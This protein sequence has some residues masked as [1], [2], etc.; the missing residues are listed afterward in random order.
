MAVAAWDLITFAQA[1]AYLNIGVAAADTNQDVW[2]QEIISDISAEI[3]LYCKRKFAIQSVS[4]E[5]YNGNGENRLLVNYWP[6]TQLST[7]TTP[8]DAQ[9]LAAVQYRNDPDSAWTDIETD[10]DHILF[11]ERWPWLQLCDE[12][13]PSGVQNVRLSYKAGY[14]TI[15]QDLKQVCL[16]MVAIEWK[17]SNRSG[18]ALLGETSKTNSGL[19]I[20]QTRTLKDMDPRWK[21]VLDRYRVP[22]I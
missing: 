4:N 13:F 1:K 19:G 16:E 10:V 22:T 17:E 7:E 12:V 21:K 18:V 6:V 5:I 20:T 8:T 11:N 14:S 2:L 3:E 9:K 15:P